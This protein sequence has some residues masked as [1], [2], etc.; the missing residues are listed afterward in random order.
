MPSLKRSND[1]KVSPVIR[2]QGSKDAPMLANSFGLPAGREFSCPGATDV[3]E[4][5]CYAGRTER[6]FTS[7][8]RLVRH[9]WDI[10]QALGDDVDALADVLGE[11]MA[12]FSAEVT[13][14]SKKTGIDA[15][16]L[17]MFRIH[18]DGD[19]YSDAYALAWSRV[20]ASTPDIQYWAYT[21]TFEAAEWLADLP[22]L[23]LYFSVDTANADTAATYALKYPTVKLAVLDETHADAS[24]TMVSIRGKR[25]PKCPEN[26]GR[27]P[28]VMSMTGRA[29]DVVAVGDIAQGACAGC[30]L[31]PKGTQDVTFSIRGR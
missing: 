12:E 14:V 30:T 8:G 6:V 26:V 2:R 27:I 16:R 23:A 15:R 22:N 1:R 4:S 5:I 29:K 25:A 9:N 21:R 17:S 10:L 7:A 24:E 13:K 19:F 18:W 11:M 20:I 28:L 3:C 31:C